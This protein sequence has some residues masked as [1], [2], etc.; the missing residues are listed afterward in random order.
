[1]DGHKVKFTIS[2]PENVTHFGLPPGS[3]VELPIEDY[4]L[5][6]VPAEI[7]NSHIEACKAQAIAARSIVYYWTS[8]GKVITDTT[9]HQAYR[10][11]LSVDKRFDRAHEAVRQTAGQVLMYDGKIAQTYYADSNGGK[12]LK[13]TDYVWKAELPYLVTKDDPWTKASGKPYKGHPVGMSQQGAIW[14]ANNGKS[15]REI[16][17]FYYPGTVIVPGEKEVPEAKPEPVKA[18]YEAYVRTQVSPLGIWEEPRKGRRLKLVP[19]GAVLGVLK[20]VNPS[21]AQVEHGGVIGYSDRQYLERIKPSEDVLYKA[22]VRTLMSPLN[23]WREA[24]RGI[25]LIK[26]P[27]GATVEVLAEVNSSFFK[28]RYKGVVGYSDP[29]YLV[30]I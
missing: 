6:V 17:D 8:N 21:W 14:A 15:H 3:I 27:K 10:G 5:G 18:L 25:S 29:K 28:V 7:G 4:L 1:M 11:P 24:R 22:V 16:L 19:R 30:K 2:N 20:E 12:M 23:I 26:I 9:Q 13:P